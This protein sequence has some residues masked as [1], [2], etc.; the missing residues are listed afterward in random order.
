MPNLI[1]HTKIKFSI[2]KPL[3]NKLPHFFT[4]RQSLA[5]TFA[6]YF[7]P[8][9]TKLCTLIIGTGNKKYFKRSIFEN[10]ELSDAG[11]HIRIR[12]Y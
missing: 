9:C 5:F 10:S 7:K 3:K 4:A 1:R 12:F 8:P 6:N 11:K 2:R